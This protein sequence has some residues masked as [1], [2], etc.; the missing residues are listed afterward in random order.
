MRILTISKYFA[1]EKT[2]IPLGRLKI[3]LYL[4]CVILGASYYLCAYRKTDRHMKWP[5]CR[6]LPCDTR[7][8]IVKQKKRASELEFLSLHCSV[9][10]EAEVLCA[11]V[12]S[13]TATFEYEPQIL[14]RAGSRLPTE[15]PQVS[16]CGDLVALNRGVHSDENTSVAPAL[17]STEV[18]LN[19]LLFLIKH[20]SMKAYRDVEVEL[21]ALLTLEV[22]GRGWLA[23]VPSW[24]GRL[25]ITARNRAPIS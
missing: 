23:S 20:P 4:N 7:I 24:V 25:D 19:L 15:Q 17:L 10:V 11:S 12:S 2:L 21:H 8:K 18:K 1:K 3:N 9:V 16:S 6:L 13:R 5:K 22:D 14:Y